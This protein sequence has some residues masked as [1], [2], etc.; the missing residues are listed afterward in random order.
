MRSIPIKG[1]TRR[2]GAP[3]GWDHEKQGL[4]HTIEVLDQ[5]IDGVNYMTTA[6]LPTADELKKLLAGYPIILGISG[7]RYPVVYMAIGGIEE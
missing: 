6:W 3:E 1:C 4:C 5:D 2:I 7:T